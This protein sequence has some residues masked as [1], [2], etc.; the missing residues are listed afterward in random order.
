MAGR[1]RRLVSG[2]HVALNRKGFSSQKRGA[3]PTSRPS[4]IVKRPRAAA[5]P[6]KSQYF[7][8]KA[9]DAADSDAEDDPSSPSSN[10]DEAS[11]FD[12]DDAVESSAEPSEDDEESDYSTEAPK[13][14][15]KPTPSKAGPSSS[16]SAAVQNGE[17][18]RPGVKAGLGPGKQ[19]VIKKPQARPAGKTPYQPETIHPNTLLFL[20][21]LKANN[22]RQWLKSKSTE[23][24]HRKDGSRTCHQCDEQLGGYSFTSYPSYP[25]Q[26]IGCRNVS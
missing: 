4:D 2:S 9:T 8:A 17:K 12:A 18:W 14:R 24:R 1:S 21:E 15:K 26:R 19:L 16:P 20:G 5:T 23:M 6:K 11:D 7:D 10:D 22:D 13:G 25:C 3:S